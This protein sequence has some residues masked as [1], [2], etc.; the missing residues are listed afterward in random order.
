MTTT[1]TKRAGKT[2]EQRKLEAESYGGT[3]K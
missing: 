3:L 1:T 2:P